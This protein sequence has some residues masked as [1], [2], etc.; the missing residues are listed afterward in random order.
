MKKKRNSLLFNLRG[1]TRFSFVCGICSKCCYGKAI[2]V[3]PYEIVR[4]ARHLGLTTGR[5]LS[6]YTEQGG[7]ILRL[8]SDGGCVFLG[9]RGCQIHADRPYVCRLYPLARR[10]DEKRKES[11]ARLPLHPECRSLR[12]REATIQAYLEAQAVEP[13]IEFNNRYE[14]IFKKM[15]GILVKTGV[16]TKMPRRATGRASQRPAEPPK[17][18]R[19]LSPWLDIDAAVAAY[20]RKRKRKVPRRLEDALELHIRAMNLWLEELKIKGISN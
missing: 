17:M 2:R 8:T 19:L 4:I 10:V 11:F 15:L 18:P 13:F 6:K 7:T 12:G 20:C 5:F 3:G 1:R 16:S 14:T 9:P